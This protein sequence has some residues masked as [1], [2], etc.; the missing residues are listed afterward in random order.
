MKKSP[1]RIRNI[2]VYPFRDMEELIDYA[3]DQNKMLLSVNAEI[4][5]RAEGKVIGIINAHIGY[6]DG[7]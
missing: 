2:D 5:M 3:A 4:I 1:I 6:A 7:Y